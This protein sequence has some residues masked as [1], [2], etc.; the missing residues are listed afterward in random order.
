MPNIDGNGKTHA[1]CNCCG[2]S[3]FSLADGRVFPHRD[4]RSLELHLP[5]RSGEVRRLRRMRRSLPDERPSFGRAPREQDRNQIE[6]PLHAFDHKWGPDKWNPDFRFDRQIIMNETGT[7]PCKVACPAHISIEGYIELAKEGRYAKPWNSSRTRTR[8][9]PSADACLQQT[10]RR[11]LHPRARSA[12]RSRSRSM[13][14][15]S[16]SL[17]STSMRIRALS[18]LSSIRN[19]MTTR[20]P[21]SV[22]GPAGLSCAYYL[23]E[24]GYSVTVF[25][26]ERSSAAC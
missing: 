7:A 21:S 3:C 26:K 1:M 18:R 19:T 8:S 5:R 14:S 20:W 12:R 2:C 10:L 9:R 11:C 6:E 24:M 17:S 4:P 13:K 23:A 15:R 22:A 25:E 16:S